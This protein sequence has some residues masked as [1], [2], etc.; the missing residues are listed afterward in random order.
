MYHSP[1]CKCINPGASRV[2]ASSYCCQL[3]QLMSLMHHISH[4][5]WNASFQQEPPA[6]VSVQPD[7]LQNVVPFQ[8][9]VL[10][11]TVASFQAK[12]YIASSC[13]QCNAM[14]QNYSCSHSPAVTSSMCGSTK[15]LLLL[16][17][18]GCIY[19]VL[20]IPVTRVSDVI[21]GMLWRNCSRAG[22]ISWQ[23]NYPPPV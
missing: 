7:I 10:F 16:V 1:N 18:A 4:P 6:P 11:Q 3:T 17:L 22:S 14:W 15:K 23:S 20:N 19:L 5:A 2:G 13:M 12:A 8:N 9:L 21:G